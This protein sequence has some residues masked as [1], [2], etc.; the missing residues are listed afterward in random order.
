MISPIINSDKPINTSTEQSGRSHNNPKTTA[1][2]PQ[3]PTQQSQAAQPNNASPEID[4]AS[5]LFDIEKNR[6]QPSETA[7]NTLEEARSTLESIVRQM[8]SSPETAAK[9]QAAKASPPLAAV[10]QSAPA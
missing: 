9:A 2:S 4:Q 1:S 8:I 3:T 10:L 7:L 6:M 5:R